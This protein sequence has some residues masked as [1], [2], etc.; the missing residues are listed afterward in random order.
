MP[1]FSVQGTIMLVAEVVLGAA[2]FY[3]AVSLA[4]EVSAALN[5]VIK[6]LTAVVGG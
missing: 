5:S 4:Q 2:G 3:C 6:P 1:K